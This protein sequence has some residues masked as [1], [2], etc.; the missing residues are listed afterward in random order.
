MAKDVDSADAS[1][2]VERRVYDLAQDALSAGKDGLLFR[3][4]T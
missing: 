3:C 1:Q 4:F 2:A